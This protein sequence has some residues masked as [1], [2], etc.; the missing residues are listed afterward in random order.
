M[1]LSKRESKSTSVE[2]SRHNRR[3]ISVERSVDIVQVVTSLISVPDKRFLF[4]NVVNHGN[5]PS[6]GIALRRPFE[7]TESLHVLSATILLVYYQ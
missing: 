2:N 5:P 7:L 4:L 6:V 1:S 3:I